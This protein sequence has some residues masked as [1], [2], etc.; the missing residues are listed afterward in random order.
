MVYAALD[1]TTIQSSGYGH[2][3]ALMMVIYPC[4]NAVRLCLFYKHRSRAGNA[5]GEN[6]EQVS[7]STILSR[8]VT[9]RCS[10]LEAK[11]NKNIFE[12]ILRK[13]L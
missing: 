9:E 12:S 4:E 8:S 2:A 6:T 11:T 13:E 3:H 10:D 7:D 5:D 1:G